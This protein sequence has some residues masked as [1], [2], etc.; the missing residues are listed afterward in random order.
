MKT[1]F[2]GCC[3]LA[4][5]NVYRKWQK[6]QAWRQQLTGEIEVLDRL[7]LDH[8]DPADLAVRRLRRWEGFDA[9][10]DDRTKRAVLLQEVG[11]RVDE[12]AELLGETSRDV[13]RGLLQR[14]RR[15]WRDGSR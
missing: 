4:F 13:V 6:E 5:P 7:R 1:Y 11:H 10:P 3:V 12:I 2:V 8:R 14:Q 15:R 9:I